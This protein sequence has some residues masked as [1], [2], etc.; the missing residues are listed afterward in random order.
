LRDGE[1]APGPLGLIFQSIPRSDFF[2][3]GLIAVLALCDP[4][5]QAR[6]ACNAP[7]A[8]EASALS[9]GVI[10][11]PPLGRPPNKSARA[12]IARALEI[13]QD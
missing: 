11:S 1:E 12:S 3:T 13:L 6:R 10:P 9:A 8:N 2:Q 4:R 5:P 7:S